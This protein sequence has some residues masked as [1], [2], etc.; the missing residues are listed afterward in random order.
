[1]PTCTT[2]LQSK[3]QEE[4][5]PRYSHGRKGEF[6]AECKTCF[7]VRMGQ[8]HQRHKLALVQEYGGKCIIC[9]YNKEPRILN[10][11]HK[12]PKTKSFGLAKKCSSNLSVLRAEAKKCILLCPNCHAELHLVGL[13][14]TAP[15]YCG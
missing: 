14:G 13:E 7:R 3:P 2:C 6:L 10:F 1:M 8:R 5:Y 12:D 9:G 4:F 11:H 15:S